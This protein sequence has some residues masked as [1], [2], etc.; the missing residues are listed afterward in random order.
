MKW[1]LV[2]LLPLSCWA[3]P[4]AYVPNEKTGTLSVIDTTTDKVVA[5]IP[6]GS[7]PR[8]LALDAERIYVS[9][10][11]KN[12]LHVIDLGRRAIQRT[13]ALGESPEGVSLSPDG[14]LVAV[15]SELGNAVILVDPRTGKLRG[16]VKTAGKNPEHAVFSPDGR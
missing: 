11:P 4:L 13:I 10:E 16:T 7:R 6:A 3:N 9:D 2:L 5:E 8:G 14:R 15:A 12:A 1:L